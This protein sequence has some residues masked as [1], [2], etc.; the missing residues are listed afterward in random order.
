MFKRFYKN[1]Y[2]YSRWDGTQNIEGLDADDI[3]NALSDD[4]MEEGNL[5]QALKSLKRSRAWSAKAY[6][7]AWMEIVNHLNRHSRQ[8]SNNL[9][10]SSK[11]R[12]G[13]KMVANKKVNKAQAAVSKG[14][15]TRAVTISLQSK[16]ARCWR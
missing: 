2:G 3:L 1:R 4:Y 14:N 16:N 8:T 13:L 15:P 10:A 5:Q 7:N 11:G 9:L 12:V 6:R